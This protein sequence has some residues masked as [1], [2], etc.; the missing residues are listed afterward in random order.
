MDG[1]KPMT[2]DLG[3]AARVVAGIRTRTPS[4]EPWDSAGIA[5]ALSDLGG[6]P[7]AALAAAC[8]A[9]EDPALRRPS[10][11][12]FRL[13]WPVNAVTTAPGARHSI[14]CDRHPDQSL[15]CPTCNRE[16]E[17]DAISDDDRRALVEQMRQDMRANPPKPARTPV[18][19][20]PPNTRL[21]QWRET[22]EE[23]P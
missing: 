3:L 4:A 15:P 5:A 11:A 1:G 14:P 17:R 22:P 19:D 16:A 18:F 7:G 23:T 20:P 2:L 13:R 8:L 6:T 21:D 10:A 9:A 12:A